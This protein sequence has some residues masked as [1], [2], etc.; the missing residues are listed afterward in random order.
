L[1][2]HFNLT[3]SAI[4]RSSNDIR[5]VIVDAFE[6]FDCFG[7]EFVTLI[8][9]QLV[10]LSPAKQ[11]EFHKTLRSVDVR[12]LNQGLSQSEQEALQEQELPEGSATLFYHLLQRCEHMPIH[13]NIHRVSCQFNGVSM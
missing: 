12:Q 8:D 3:E 6:A 10:L 4:K 13:H 2:T 5:N 1:E 7:T 11:K 9:L